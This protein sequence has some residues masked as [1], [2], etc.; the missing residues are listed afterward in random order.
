MALWGIS[1]EP[2]WTTIEAALAPASNKAYR[3]TFCNFL[4]FLDK[5]GRDMT[6]VGVVDVLSFIQEFVDKKRAKS[7]IRGVF[8]ALLHFFTLFQKEHIIKAPIIALHVLGA[9]RLA[10]VNDRVPFV[11][12]PEIPLKFISGRPY[13]HLFRPAGKEA[14]LLLLL[15][16]GIR[17]SDA[18]R[19]SKKM[20]KTG[21]VWAIPYLEARKTGPSPPQLVRAYADARLCPVRA[22]QRYLAIAN[23][24]RK[25]NQPFMF[26]SSRG[27]RADVD[28]L[29]HWVF[30]LLEASGITASAGS[31]RSASTS[32]A[33]ERK[34][35]IDNVLKSAGW[36]KEGT[37]RRFYQRAVHPRLNGESLLPP[38]Q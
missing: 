17:V 22:L 28:T 33:V 15:S 3:A 37:F 31:C 14:L 4:R 1:D 16:T 18:H 19:L 38:M 30:E 5:V 36:A 20:V 10:P 35:D 34:M 32:A 9:Q 26:I 6:T 29:R 7:T 21:E 25:P 8:A 12:D 27:F 13:P 2:T 23:P 24:I 11:W